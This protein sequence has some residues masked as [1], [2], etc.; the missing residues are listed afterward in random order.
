MC[1]SSQKQRHR[2]P[3]GSLIGNVDI[4]L[5]YTSNASATWFDTYYSLHTFPSPLQPSRFCL[6]ANICGHAL[7]RI[8]TNSISVVRRV[9]G[10]GLDGKLLGTLGERMRAQ[11]KSGRV[12]QPKAVVDRWN[13]ATPDPRADLARRCIIEAELDVM[14]GQTRLR[15]LKSMGL[16]TADAEGALSQSNMKLLQMRNHYEIVDNL[17]SPSPINKAHR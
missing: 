10:F 17:L 16:D 8:H 7:V 3:S 6:E 14:R 15:N 12:T 11:A 1:S 5:A 9:L 4:W 2:H 13:A